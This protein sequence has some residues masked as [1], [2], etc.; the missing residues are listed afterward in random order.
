MTDY[1]YRAIFQTVK[2]GV[3]SKNFWKEFNRNFCD[4]ASLSHTEFSLYGIGFHYKLGKQYLSGLLKSEALIRN[5][6]T[7]GYYMG[8]IFHYLDRK[9][10][11]EERTKTQT[12]TQVCIKKS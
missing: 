8:D 3:P 2:D 9:L 6:Y 5:P 12:K 7:S 10:N 1:I 4:T 11:R